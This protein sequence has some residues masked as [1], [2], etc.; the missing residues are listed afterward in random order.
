VSRPAIIF[1]DEPT[2]NLDRRASLELLDFLRRAVR[3]FGQ[4]IVMV[5]HDG[6]GAACADR[7]VFLADG[8]IVDDL[9]APTVERILEVTTTLG[10][11]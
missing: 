9:A 10:D 7:V 6:A 8:R 5:T 1:A 11:S 2:G 3:D 4:T